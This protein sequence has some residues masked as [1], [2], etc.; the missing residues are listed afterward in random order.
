MDGK[1][2]Q[3]LLDVGLDLVAHYDNRGL[4]SSIWQGSTAASPLSSWAIQQMAARATWGHTPGDAIARQAAVEEFASVLTI[5]IPV[6]GGGFIIGAVANWLT[7]QAAQQLADQLERAVR[8]EFGPKWA[9]L[10]TVGIGA[11]TFVFVELIR[12]SSNQ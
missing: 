12:R 6:P 11:A 4:Q 8:K 5:L 7:G 9:P 3:R 2:A 10:V 1:Q